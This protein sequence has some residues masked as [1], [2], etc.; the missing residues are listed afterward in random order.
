M[1]IP[2]R[3]REGVGWGEISVTTAT[4]ASMGTGI[5]SARSARFAAELANNPSI[6]YPRLKER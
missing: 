5:W 1:G 2:T 6:F 3:Q 4:I